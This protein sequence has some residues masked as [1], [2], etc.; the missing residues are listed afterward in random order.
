MAHRSPLDVKQRQKKKCVACP[1]SDRRKAVVM[2]GC[3]SSLYLCLVNFL[4]LIMVF[5][6]CSSTMSIHT[7]LWLLWSYVQ[8][9]IL[10]QYMS[11]FF[12]FFH[13]HTLSLMEVQYMF[14]Q[15]YAI[16]TLNIFQTSF[17]CFW[18]VL[19]VVF[20]ASPANTSFLPRI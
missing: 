8:N 17:I 13:F 19:V 6:R 2:V 11:A 12:I 20:P 15:Q 10:L 3:G 16:L 9:Y 5:T 4:C 18:R 14:S 1:S 7:L